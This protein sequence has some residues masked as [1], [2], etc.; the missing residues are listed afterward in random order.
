M[1]KVSTNFAIPSLLLLI[2]VLSHASYDLIGS[3]YPDDPVA[4]GKAWA[5]VLRGFEATVLY[6]I[7]WLLL[8]WEPIGMRIAGSVVCAWGALESF[9]ISACRL[10]FPMGQPPPIV[11]PFTG[12]CDTV[13]G[14]PIY[15]ITITV[16]LLISFL[17]Q[18]RK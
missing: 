18:P 10:Q 17:R 8:P 5:Y 6:L 3:F 4:A 7:V 2:V 13:T 11:K 9:Q 14:A 12:L 15:M 16:V 1:K